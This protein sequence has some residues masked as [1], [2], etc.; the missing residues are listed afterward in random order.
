MIPTP[1]ISGVKG[2]RR[3]WRRVTIPAPAVGTDWS[4]VVPGGRLWELLS[5]FGSLAASAAAVTRRPR[6]TVNDGAGVAL[7]IPANTNLAASTTNTY[8]WAQGATSTSAG[9]DSCMG[10]PDMYLPAGFTIA[11]ATLNL[12]VG[13]QW[14]AIQLT[15]YEYD[16][17][18]GPAQLD[19]PE[20]VSVVV[21]TAPEG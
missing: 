16:I 2:T 17:R 3:Y 18:T 21:I 20:P 8:T 19:E 6:L 11:A 10:I 13:D 14:T 4:Q 15:V 7:Q 9:T 5:I 1:P 12:D